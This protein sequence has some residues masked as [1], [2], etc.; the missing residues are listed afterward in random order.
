MIKLEDKNLL[1]FYE[2]YMIAYNGVVYYCQFY[3]SDDFPD[4]KDKGIFVIQNHYDTEILCSYW[5]V[6][7]VWSLT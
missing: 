5:D 7:V 4:R 2:D 3:P 1:D 6:T